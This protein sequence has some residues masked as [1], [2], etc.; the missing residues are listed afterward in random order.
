M[1]NEAAY[2]TLII[3]FANRRKHS[4]K[5]SHRTL[6]LKQNVCPVS[7]RLHYGHNLIV[8]HISIMHHAINVGGYN[9]FVTAGPA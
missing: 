4:Q 8:S 6:Q 3:K 9:D 5:P 1:K 2:A 7:K